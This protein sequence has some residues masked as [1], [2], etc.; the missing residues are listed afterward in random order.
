ML[1]T[2]ADH[3]YAKSLENRPHCYIPLKGGLLDVSCC[4]LDNFANFFHFS[5]KESYY[6]NF[7][8][9]SAIE[10]CH[11][12]R[13]G[14]ASCMWTCWDWIRSTLEISTPSSTSITTQTFRIGASKSYSIN[15]LF[16]VVEKWFKCMPFGNIILGP[17][18]IFIRVTCDPASSLSSSGSLM[19]RVVT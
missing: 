9:N 19:T 2:Y 8:L 16:N 14:M 13:L 17:D 15:K 10:D 5:C 4:K 11:H 7:Y 12:L 3:T 1:E 6:W 18:L